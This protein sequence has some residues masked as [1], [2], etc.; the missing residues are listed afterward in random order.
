MAIVVPGMH[1]IIPV[2][3]GRMART[4]GVTIT[5][6]RIY[7]LTTTTATMITSDDIVILD[8]GNEKNGF[9]KTKQ[10][11]LDMTAAYCGATLKKAAVLLQEY[12]AHMQDGDCCACCTIL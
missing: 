6:A 7:P 11:D 1:Q 4:G 9:D 10:H 2:V 5:K 12:D 8:D 3:K